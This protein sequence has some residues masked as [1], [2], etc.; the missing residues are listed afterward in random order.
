[1]VK[2]LH[3]T[4]SLQH[5]SIPLFTVL[6]NTTTIFLAIGEYYMFK[7][8]IS[9]IDFFSFFLII[10]GNVVTCTDVN[11]F[12][13]FYGLFW[14][15]MNISFTFMYLVIF[16]DLILVEDEISNGWTIN[17][18]WKFWSYC[19]QQFFI[20]SIPFYICISIWGN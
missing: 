15:F 16:N 5:I 4:F 9:W 14:T 13:T 10:F 8:R 1:M 18:T 11:I 20:N 3:L 19:L 12:F 7:R 6:K 2:S 17:K